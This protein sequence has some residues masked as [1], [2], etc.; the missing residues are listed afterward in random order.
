MEYIAV[1][2]IGLG[3][4]ASLLENDPLRE[5]PCTHAGA[6][7]DNPA[8]FIA[9]G[10]DNN[11]ERRELFSQRWHCPSYTDAQTMITHHKPQIV[12]VAT[13]PEFHAEYCSLASALNVPFIICEKPLAD[14]LQKARCISALKSR[15]L[16]N[17]ERRYAKNYQKAR[18]IIKNQQLLSVKGTICMG[19]NRTLRTVLWNDATHLIDMLLFLSG[20]HT[21]KHKYCGGADLDSRSGS[22]FLIGLLDDSIPFC[23]EIGAERDHLIFEIECSYATG[24]I[25]IGNDVFEL[26]ESGPSVYAERFRS[27]F[28]IQETFKGPTG[29]FVNMIADAVDCV[30]DSRRLPLSSAQDALAG[31]EYLDSLAYSLEN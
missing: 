25:R 17:H 21:I 3:R 19:K 23:I 22:A 10:M 20:A 11:A 2:F 1:A 18:E 4:I 14:S 9:A 28:K 31:I 26:W 8:C 15:I 16:V 6:V 5:K 27:L 24:K 30:R 29:Y 7:A 12:I 13:D